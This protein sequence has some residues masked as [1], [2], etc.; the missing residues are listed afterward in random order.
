MKLREKYGTPLY[1]YDERIMK[2]SAEAALAFP[3]AFGLTV[4][5]AMKALPNGT[6]LNLF[7]KWGLSFD[8]SSVWEARRAILAGIPAGKICLSTQE[9]SPEFAE[10]V[11]EGIEVNLCSL[12]QIE[13]FG[14]I[15]PGREVGIRLNPGV[16]SGL[17]NRLSTGGLAASFGIWFEWIDEIHKLV[18][19][20]R[21]RV[22]RLHTH[23]GTGGDPD[24]WFDTATQSL[25]HLESFPDV[26]TMD[27]GGG[28][29]VARVPGEKAVDMQAVGYA[30]KQA[31]EHIERE[32]GRRIHLEIEPGN[33]LAANS[34]AILTTV[35]DI[36]S[37]GV[38][39]YTFLKVDTGMT[40]ILRPSLYG[41]QHGIQVLSEFPAVAEQDYV[42]VGHCCE[43]GD[44]ITI[45][46]GDP[47]KLNPR[48]MEPVQINDMLLITGAGAYCSAMPAKNY[49]S[50][51][52][53][54]EV[55]YKES[56]EFALIRRRQTLEQVVQN[57]IR[58][59]LSD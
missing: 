38:E 36:V 34:G 59:D 6:I 7:S 5:F 13:Q 43:S 55:L 58:A 30:V 24:R 23:I 41:A 35:Q 4:R 26:H 10:L 1:L 54:P 27:L 44:V 39:G 19:R 3:N 33:F 31:F 16:G 8:A 57:E 15:F 37:T 14:K 20:Y 46:P 21:L 25:E 47:E 52:E 29:K 42:V 53:S 48:K 12:R 18:E 2:A 45:Q 49:N 40:D 9:L 22:V 11:K 28:F 51:P 32:T 17:N 56:G 50:F